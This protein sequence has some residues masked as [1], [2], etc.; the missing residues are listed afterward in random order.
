MEA[1]TGFPAVLQPHPLTAIKITSARL[2]EVTS[3]SPISR[4]RLMGAM[5]VTKRGSA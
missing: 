4:S 3:C 1:V 5:V 2:R